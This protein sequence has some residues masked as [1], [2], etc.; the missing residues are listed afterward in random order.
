MIAFVLHDQLK[1]FGNYPARLLQ[2]STAT[3]SVIKYITYIAF[4][5][6][7][8]KRAAFTLTLCFGSML[9]CATCLCSSSKLK[10]SQS[11]TGFRQAEYNHSLQLRLNTTAFR[12]CCCDV[13]TPLSVSLCLSRKVIVHHGHVSYQVTQDAIQLS[14]L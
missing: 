9:F 6:N 1:S 4:V 3:T 14:L 13:R 7:V 11:M 12:T 8:E 10:L 2:G 5:C